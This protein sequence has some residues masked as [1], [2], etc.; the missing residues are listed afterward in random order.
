[1]VIVLHV[2]WHP[3]GGS[4]IPSVYRPSRMAS[5]KT[6]DN[7][8][9][10]QALLHGPAQSVCKQLRFLLCNGLMS[11]LYSY[12]C[13]PVLMLDIIK[14]GKPACPLCS[15][16]LLQFLHET[17]PR[18]AFTLSAGVPESQIM[19]PLSIQVLRRVRNRGPDASVASPGR[20]EGR[21]CLQLSFMCLHHD[22]HLFEEE[23]IPWTMATVI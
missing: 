7:V 9:L 18:D 16:P 5:R 22:S 23:N 1:M 19:H 20:H 13:R 3:G 6:Q 14:S 2:S 12:S 15:T 17:A 21:A 10:D 8:Y 4:S 11:I